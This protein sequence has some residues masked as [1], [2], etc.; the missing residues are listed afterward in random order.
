MKILNWA[1]RNSGPFFLFTDSVALIFS[2][3]ILFGYN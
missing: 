1:R 2:F 3:G